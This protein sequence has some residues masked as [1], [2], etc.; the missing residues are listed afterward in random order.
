[1]VALPNTT[2]ALARGARHWDPRDL[3]THTPAV[4]NLQ[5]RHSATST[6]GDAEF[7]LRQQAV[8]PPAQL[9]RVIRK[10]DLNDEESRAL[11]LQ[12]EALEEVFRAR[13]LQATLAE[14]NED[15]EPYVKSK[16]KRIEDALSL[17][18]QSDLGGAQIKKIYE[19]V[20]L[21][22]RDHTE[23]L[24]FREQLR[25]RAAAILADIRGL[26]TRI[27][28]D[29]NQ[30]PDGIWTRVR[31]ELFREAQ[32]E[33]RPELKNLLQAYARKSLQRIFVLNP[34]VNPEAGQKLVDDLTSYLIRSTYY[35][36]IQE[37]LRRL[38]EL[39][40]D[41]G[42]EELKQF[43]DT[44]T[45]LRQY[46]IAEHPDYLVFEYMMRILI[47]KDQVENLELLT[48]ERTTLL[49]M[50]MGSGK[51][52]VL[53]PIASHQNAISGRQ[54]SVVVLPEALIPSM[55]KQL[56]SQLESVFG[57]GVDR[58]NIK[59]KDKYDLEKLRY[60]YF[61][62]RKDLDNER[63]VVTSNNSIQ[64]LFLIFIE[65]LYDY[66]KLN[67][68]EKQTRRQE[69]ASLQDIFQLFRNYGYALIDEVDSI[70]DIMASHR[71]SIGD[72]VQI[73][74]SI[75]DATIG[76][77]RLLAEDQQIHQQVK[78]PFLAA[79][80]ASNVS[81]SALPYSKENYHRVIQDRLIDLVCRRD[82]ATYFFHQQESIE[83]F[84]N[85]DPLALKRYLKSTSISET[86]DFIGS[87]TDDHLK[88]VLSVLFTQIHQT[89]PMTLDRTYLVHYGLCPEDKKLE[90][91]PLNTAESRNLPSVCHPWIGIPYHSGS[92]VV[93]SR[94]GTD[95][96]SLNYTIQSHL[97]KH[98]VLS[99]LLPE[100]ER[101]KKQFRVSRSQM[102]KDQINSYFEVPLRDGQ[103]LN[104]SIAQIQAR[105]QWVSSRPGLVLDLIKTH[106]VSKIEVFSDQLFTNSH[107]YPIMFKKINGITSPFQS[108]MNI[109]FPP[110]LLRGP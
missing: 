94:F 43:Y 99:M 73:E 54:L 107:I 50:I 39:F 97:E 69:I 45:A 27:E 10:R 66:D 79:L 13:P 41:S 44:A 67:D 57:Q 46:D 77:Y 59:R 86:Q 28:E 37:T 12:Y 1:M 42:P 101:L 64:S 35:F 80:N 85:L 7:D 52:S 76:I 16:L 47:R 6:N 4:A 49:E 102:I 17:K 91:D 100:I 32:V 96:E 5:F 74:S 81:D 26:K 110:I 89:L 87:L 60:L 38:N 25:T 56:N 82:S 108:F 48:G 61:R 78:I 72:R 95:L 21:S 18:K 3:N 36:R 51:T 19:W 98:N 106:A 15:Y 33:V 68:T 23:L 65:A 71:F 62:L 22:S 103:I 63:V 84:R 104:L 11:A 30:L 105:V 75:V 40:V 20:D 90:Q 109:V 2:Q 14:E 34:G 58:I 92:P 55:V 29:F 9:A 83:Q 93:N 24:V 8:I 53:L 31:E 70:L 88:N